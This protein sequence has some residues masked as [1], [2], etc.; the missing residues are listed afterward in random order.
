MMDDYVRTNLP[1]LNIFIILSKRSI[2]KIENW[3]IMDKYF[4]G[5]TLI[6][7]IRVLEILFHASE[8]IYRWQKVTKINM[9]HD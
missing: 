1:S 9:E 8:H 2:I 3:F 4:N 5:M 6:R 7:L